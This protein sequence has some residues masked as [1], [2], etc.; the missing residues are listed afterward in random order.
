[1]TLSHQARQ[2]ALERAFSSL[3]IADMT[4]RLTLTQLGIVECLLKAGMKHA[5]IAEEAKCSIPTVKKM[6][7]NLKTWGSLHPLKRKV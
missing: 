4:P 2:P 3:K 5:N 1:M 6:S 7:S